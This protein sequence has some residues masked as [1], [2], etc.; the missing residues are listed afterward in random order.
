MFVLIKKKTIFAKKQI[1]TRMENIIK[2]VANFFG[3]TA[4]QLKE[5]NASAN[6][7]KARNFLYYIL[8]FD[9][10]YSSA[11]ISKTLNRTQRQVVRQ[12]AITKYRIE[13]FKDY[14]DL[15]LKLSKELK[16]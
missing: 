9:C 12:N 14:N 1:Y 15:Y 10:N 3:F 5:K 16:Y 8:H 2:Q 6:V 13:N 4:E 7:S 11:K